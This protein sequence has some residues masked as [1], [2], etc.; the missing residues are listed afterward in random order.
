M[1]LIYLLM[2]ATAG[3]V[4]GR[5][6]QRGDLIGLKCFSD[7][8]SDHYGSADGLPYGYRIS[9]DSAEA[10]LLQE[11]KDDGSGNRRWCVDLASFPANIMS[12][13]TA[14]ETVHIQWSDLQNYIEAR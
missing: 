9:T 3:R 13:L 14:G 7:R 1:D 6:T 8:C 12:Q 11:T 10:N 5:G 2:K 4:D